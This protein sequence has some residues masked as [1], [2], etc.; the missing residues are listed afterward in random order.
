M[1]TTPYVREGIA[2]LRQ[3]RR[4]GR[5][6]VSGRPVFEPPPQQQDVPRFIG[7]FDQD[8]GIH[9]PA[10]PS[11][12]LG[13]GPAGI[14]AGGIVRPRYT[15]GQEFQLFSQKDPS[16]IKRI[17]SQLITSGLLDPQHGTPG[18]WTPQTA[19]AME[20][21]LGH[22]NATGQSWHGALTELVHAGEIAGYGETGPEDPAFVPTPFIPRTFLEPD[23]KVARQLVKDMITQVVGEEYITEDLVDKY[24]ASLLSDY[25]REFN[26]QESLRREQHEASE[27][28]SESQ[29]S[30][31]FN[32]GEVVDESDLDISQSVTAV[33]PQAELRAELEQRFRKTKAGL[34]D[35]ENASQKNSLFS[36]LD[37]MV[38][39][40]R[41]SQVQTL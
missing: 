15:Q 18:S 10:D 32:D 27:Q 28:I 39:I 23:T 29:H 2:R 20:Q 38:N 1:S 19:R 37:S 40:G 22:A 14:G 35:F 4:T 26:I 6:Q 41:G 33:D 7:G 3:E 5:S 8:Y 24:T 36:T 16:L 31:T 21:V 30:F 9:I 25:R 11:S 17:Q 34:R 13:S 12:Y